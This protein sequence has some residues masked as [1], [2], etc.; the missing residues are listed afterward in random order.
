L[1]GTIFVKRAMVV[2]A[3]FLIGVEGI[4]AIL[5]AVVAKFT[6]SYHLRETGLAWLGWFVPYS[7]SDYRAQ[8][9]P[10]WPVWMHIYWKSR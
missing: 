5:P 8:F 4:L 1:I 7:E 9:G 3:G 2:G 6:M 10:G